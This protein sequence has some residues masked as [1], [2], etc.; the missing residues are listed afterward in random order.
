MTEWNA[1]GLYLSY[2]G[3]LINTWAHYA[4]TY[5]KATGFGR[6]YR[7][8]L[9]VLEQ[10][11]GTP[12]WNTALPL[13]FGHSLNEVNNPYQGQLDEITLYTRPLTIAEVSAI[14][15][16]GT[17]GKTPPDAWMAPRSAPEPPAWRPCGGP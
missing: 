14:H 10:S 16:S 2:G 8:G 5:D 9:L 13:T 17:D 6:I 7:D 11:I 15:A 3:M 12:A 4:I 1:G